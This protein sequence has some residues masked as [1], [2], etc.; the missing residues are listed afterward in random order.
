VGKHH[1]EEAVSEA[2]ET[3]ERLE[4]LVRQGLTTRVGLLGFDAR[5]KHM[6]QLLY[7]EGAR[8]CPYPVETDELDAEPLPEA[9]EPVEDEPE[10]RSLFV[11]GQPEPIA[12]ITVP[13]GVPATDLRIWAEGEPEPSGRPPVVCADGVTALWDPEHEGWSRQKVT[14]HPVPEGAPKGSVGAVTLGPLGMD[15]DE[16]LA[17]H[18][19][20]REA[21][22]HESRLVT[23]HW[24]S[25][26]DKAS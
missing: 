5:C 17:D 4:A 6:A 11:S 19:P 8:L 22:E 7:D 16:M 1:Q 9:A 18:G 23:E 15:W 10:T 12:V 3:L 21:T 25:T 20:V 14:H 26:E 2:T 13:A 24:P